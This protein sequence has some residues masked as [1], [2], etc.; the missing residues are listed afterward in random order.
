MTCTR[1]V[2]WWM[3]SVYRSLF[4]LLVNGIVLVDDLCSGTF[5]SR[6]VTMQS[7]YS[8]GAGMKDTIS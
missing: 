7:D 1:R 8:F 6:G 3:C 5:L 2:W 4:L